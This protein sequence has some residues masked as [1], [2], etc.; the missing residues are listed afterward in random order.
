MVVRTGLSDTA[1]CSIASKN[2]LSYARVFFNSLRRFHQD[3][4]LHLLLVDRVD[5][6]FNPEEEIFKITEIEELPINEIYSFC[7]KYNVTELNT[8][9]KPF[10]IEYLFTKYGYKKVIYFDPDI[11]VMQGLDSLFRIL[12]DHSVLLIPHITSPIPED[13]KTVS[14][15]GI[16]M[17]GTYNLGFI[18][19]SNYEKV[20][21]VLNWWKERLYN[22]CFSAPEKGMFVDQKWIDLV[23]AMLEDVYILREPGYNVAYWNLHERDVVFKD[24]RY[25]VNGG[26]LYFFHFSG[27]VFADIECISKY[28]NRF[29]LKE[30]PTLRRLFERYR[31]L[32][33]Q[34]DYLKT[35]EWPYAFGF[36]D[37]GV[38][39]TDLLRKFYW[40]L[41]H[42]GR[43]FGNPF[44]TGPED[45]FYN[46]LNKRVVQDKPITNLLHYIY[47]L[48][49]DLQRAFPDPFGRDLYRFVDWART[50][51]KKEYGLD[52][53]LMPFLQDQIVEMRESS[54]AFRLQ[55]YKLKR[56]LKQLVW[57]TGTRY[58][59][60]VKRIPLLNSYAER[61][62]TR[63][64]M[65]GFLVSTSY[66]VEE[67]IERMNTTG[68]D[69]KLGVNIAGYID[70]ESGVGESVR[71]IIRACQ[72]TDIPFVL[73]NIEQ[74]F[75]RRQ[76]RTYTEFSNDNP[77]R[78][79]LLH[80][81]ADQ[82]PLVARSL[83]EEYFRDRYNIGY[84]YWELS[85]FPEEFHGAY[86]LFNE[87]W[88][89]SAFCQESIS[90]TSP[91]PVVKI[92]PPVEVR[93]ER[94]YDRR[95]FGIPE[96]AFVF[97]MLFDFLSFIERKNPMAVIK[98]FRM[99]FGRGE[100]V[101]LVVKST[102]ARYHREAFQ[103]LVDDVRGDNVL[104]IDRYLNRDELHSLMNVCD[105]YVSLHRSEGF[106]LPMAE[107]MFLGK[108]VIATGYS[109]NLEFM[110]VENSF[111]VKYRLVELQRD[112]GPYKKGNLWAEPDVEHAAELMRFVAEHPED[113]CQ[114]AKRGSEFV[115]GFF[116]AQLIGKKIKERIEIIAN[117]ND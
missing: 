35:R 104:I 38:P 112:Y 95:H 46:Y 100:D 91:V 88:V 42:Q 19:F 2:Y 97:M 4:D 24:E 90:A 52:D 86:G 20:R 51:L 79:N 98:A 110:N 48:R 80:V 13:G 69:R 62:Y 50:S 81:N 84:W 77:Y 99:A 15:I 28:Q 101:M 47:Y 7:F 56:K 26:P 105:C 74:Q 36:F 16:L 76:D 82:A 44:E 108:P 67:A 11:L 18:G 31:D 43:D 70:T 78:I 65:E 103:K 64:S 75:Y 5:G 41:R 14:E 92:P 55:A 114:V 39:I 10:F 27:F 85:R 25:Y 54:R 30:L 21:Y 57:N 66:D 17:A 93:I 58:A 73:N 6:F 106:G 59:G 3:V 83:G 23:P 68:S 60:I 22:H 9:V 34:H 102:N 40:G 45:S 63:L 109:G 8:A 49:V 33:V 117:C 72:E 96:N 29:T 116:S 32:L 87:I 71:C 61:V 89:A 37:N 107:A 53:R 111:L 1:V 94:P 113:A 115:K 12:E